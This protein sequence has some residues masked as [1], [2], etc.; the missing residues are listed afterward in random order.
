MKR[1]IVMRHA[2]SDWSGTAMTD[3]DRALN[4]RGRSSAVALGNWL[5]DIDLTPDTILCSSAMRTRETLLRL[6]LAEPETDTTTTRDLYLASEDQ[7]LAALQRAKGA[8]VLIIG[9]NPGIGTFAANILG[10][11]HPHPEFRMYPT[12]AT[13]IA[14]FDID[15]WARANWQNAIARHFTVPRDL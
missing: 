3:H 8:C 10:A 9:H 7:I 11:T 13:L 1:V 2:K 5:R 4:K 12:G 6:N 14:D 15:T